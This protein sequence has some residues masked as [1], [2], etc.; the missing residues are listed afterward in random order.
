MQIRTK[1]GDNET[2]QNADTVIPWGLP[3][4]PTVVT[5]VTPLAKRDRASLNSSS[6]TDTIKSNLAYPN[7][8]RKKLGDFD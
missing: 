8:S 4:A 5:T 6:V 7:R 1:G 2:E 3:S